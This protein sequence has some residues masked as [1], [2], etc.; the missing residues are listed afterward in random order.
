MQYFME[1]LDYPFTHPIEM[2]ITHRYLLARQEGSN[3]ERV[4]AGCTTNSW[5]R[6]DAM[7]EREVGS[8]HH[9][10]GSG[11]EVYE[12]TQSAAVGIIMKCRSPIVA[13]PNPPQ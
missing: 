2:K 5:V 4:L 10:D 12:I 6:Y 8:L 13:T 11:H 9:G 7:T 3:T 1:I